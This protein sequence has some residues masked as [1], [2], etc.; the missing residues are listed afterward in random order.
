[1]KKTSAGFTIIEL[2]VVIVI[3]AI[4]AT[5]SIVGFSTIQQGARNTQ[6]SSQINTIAEA[7]EKYYMK[8]GEYP[9]CTQ[10]IQSSATVVSSVLPG[11]DPNNLT[12][13]GDLTAGHN[14]F[15]CSAPTSSQFGYLN[16][17]NSCTVEYQEEGNSNPPITV[18]CRHHANSPNYTLTLVTSTG[19]NVSIGG[20]FAAGSTPTMTATPSQ[21]YQGLSNNTAVWTGSSGCSG[22]GNGLSHTITMDSDKTCTA[23]FE[24]IPIATLAARTV[25]PST[26]GST[27]TYSW[28]SAAA[29]C[30]TN[31]A[32]YQYRLTAAPTGDPGTIT[33]DSGMIQ[34]AS[35]SVGFDTSIQGQTY[36]LTAQANCYNVA[37]SGS[38]SPVASGAYSRPWST[39][40]TPGVYVAGSDGTYTT[41]AWGAVSCPGNSTRYYYLY[42]DSRGGYSGWQG[43]ITGTAV[44]YNTSTQGVGYY[45]QAEAECYNSG[46]ASGV[47]STSAAILYYRPYQYTLSLSGINGSPSGAGMYTE[48]TVASFSGTA[49]RGAGFTSWSGDCAGQGQSGS[50]TMNGNKSCTINFF[51]Y[52]YPVAL[53][54]YWT[55]WVNYSDDGNNTYKTSNTGNSAP[56]GGTGADPYNPTW[57]NLVDPRYN[58]VDWSAYPSQA[59]CAAMG[60]RLP[61]ASELSGMYGARN[62]IGNVPGTV[63]RSSSQWPIANGTQTYNLSLVSGT[64]SYINKAN[65]VMFR[66]VA[67]DAAM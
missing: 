24:P 2:V 64:Y 45:I 67:D 22:G 39:P 53:G 43:P 56:Q 32:G 12:A 8:N 42:T 21:F 9:S 50:I 16:G 52:W 15:V 54:S 47:G 65:G 66:C 7:L 11:L 5:I 26:V 60:G 31:T 41:W 58:G 36:T 14:S 28:N 49:N 29:E 35:T 59:A 6:R 48:G 55:Y 17:G 23:H 20:T 18:D 3:I 38:W 30:G 63:Y 44:A 27:T 34:T 40:A 46:G 4:L 10:M 33:Y 61:Y 1:M 51:Q 37:T 19:G 13:P 25:T 62:S 57:N